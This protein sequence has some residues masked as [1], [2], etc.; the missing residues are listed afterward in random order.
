MKI[1]AKL[2]VWMIKLSLFYYVGLILGLGSFDPESSLL[3]QNWKVYIF[4]YLPLAM[5]T[6]GLLVAAI[7]AYEESKEDDSPALNP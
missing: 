3:Y 4:L 5:G 2:I 1:T 7:E 6:E